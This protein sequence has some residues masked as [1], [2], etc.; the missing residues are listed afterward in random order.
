VAIWQIVFGERRDSLS[1]LQFSG[2]L[3]YGSNIVKRRQ[4][5]VPG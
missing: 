4:V 2:E 5:S 3:V 1:W